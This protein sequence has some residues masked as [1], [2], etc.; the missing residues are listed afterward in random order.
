MESVGPQDGT[1]CQPEYLNADCRQQ[2]K[3]NAYNTE[4]ALSLAKFVHITLCESFQR[5]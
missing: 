1:Q 2:R 5:N 4:Y 3:I